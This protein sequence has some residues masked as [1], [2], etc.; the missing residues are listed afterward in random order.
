MEHHPEDFFVE[1]S[2]VFE[3]G[4]VAESLPVAYPDQLFRIAV[5]IIAHLQLLPFA[6]QERGVTI[7]HEREE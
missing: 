5:C 1:G 3:V 7:C 4:V 2:G 6:Q